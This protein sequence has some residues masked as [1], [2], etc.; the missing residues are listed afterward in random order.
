MAWPADARERPTS[1]AGTGGGADGGAGVRRVF[2]AEQERIYRESLRD[3]GPAFTRRFVAL[4]GCSE[5]ETGLAIDLGERRAS[6]DFIRPAFPDTGLC[7]AFRRRAA[8]YG[9]ILRYRR[10]SACSPVRTCR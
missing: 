5:H 8:R 10:L 3:N 9:F 7:S 4:P 2:R 1:H 6:I